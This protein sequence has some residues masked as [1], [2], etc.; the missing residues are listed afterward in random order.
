MQG[1]LPRM[2]VR[3][4]LQ[5]TSFHAAIAEEYR[6]LVTSALQRPRGEIGVTYVLD[7]SFCYV[8]ATLSLT[9]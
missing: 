6:G 5:I 1:I 8:Y 9:L 2:Y 3:M 4:C 7:E